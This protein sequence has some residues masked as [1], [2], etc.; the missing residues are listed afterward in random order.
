MKSRGKP[1]SI[2]KPYLENRMIKTVTMFLIASKTLSQF[3]IGMKY[4]GNTLTV[5]CE[6]KFY[7]NTKFFAMRVKED[8]GKPISF[9]INTPVIKTADQYILDGGVMRYGAYEPGNNCYYHTDRAGENAYPMFIIVVRFN[10][11]VDKNNCRLERIIT[12][13]GMKQCGKDDTEDLS[14]IISY[15]KDDDSL[16]PDS[17]FGKISWNGDFDFGA[18]KPILME[19]YETFD[20][21]NIN[22]EIIEAI[23]LK[24]IMYARSK[25]PADA[26]SYHAG[27]ISE[28][29]DWNE[30]ASPIN[31]GKGAKRMV[32]DD[33]PGY[34]LGVY[35]G[36]G[37][38]SSKFFCYCGEIVT[39]GL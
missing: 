22:K 30:F 17:A 37:D 39:V 24:P 5:D 3:S 34:Y 31:L 14:T 20:L 13:I 12:N 18:Y 27:E 38:D 6:D 4:P 23:I 29:L 2:R 36:P 10:G 16:A 35:N 33:L 15:R 9:K 8:S 1:K 25:D 21:T 19:F 32:Q 26:V 7:Q 28:A 11:A